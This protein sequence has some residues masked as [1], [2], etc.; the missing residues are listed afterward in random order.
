MA[1]KSIFLTPEGKRKLEAELEY[2][3]SVRRREVAERIHAAKEG[4]DIMESAGYEAAKNEQAFLEG[5]ILSL[6]A[7]LKNAVVIDDEGPSDE[8]RF[9]SYVTVRERGGEEET[10]RIVGSAEVDPINGLISNE[11]PLGMALLGHR[12]GEEVAVQTPSGPRYFEI[13][14]IR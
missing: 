10:L 14:R 9:G 4:G 12:V 11:S 13:V 5:R 2:L 8:V 7:I 1:D 6:E 3:C